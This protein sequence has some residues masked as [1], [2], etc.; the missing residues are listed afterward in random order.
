MNIRSFIGV[1]SAILI[2]WLGA[3]YLH[4]VPTER[5]RQAADSSS[6]ISGKTD[7]ASLEMV[8]ENESENR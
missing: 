7:D 2:A 6:P 1:S 3:T 5:Y 8:A 4:E